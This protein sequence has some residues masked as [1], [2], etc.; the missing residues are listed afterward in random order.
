MANVSC[1]YHPKAEVIDRGELICQDC[2]LVLSNLNLCVK[3]GEPIFSLFDISKYVT[4]IKDVCAN[5]HF[6]KAVVSEA[7]E[8]FN[9]TANHNSLNSVRAMAC[10]YIACKFHK[11]PVVPEDIQTYSGIDMHKLV[12][13][14]EEIEQR[15]G[16]N[17]P[18]FPAESFVAKICYPLNMP[19]KVEK[20]ALVIIRAAKELELLVIRKD[21]HLAVTAIFI[22]SHIM[23]KPVDKRH[24]FS[25]LLISK[26]TFNKIYKTLTNVKT[27][28]LLI[29]A[30]YL[31]LNLPNKV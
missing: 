9:K 7:I 27:I 25:M 19:F 29:P 31:P 12:L 21:E 1:T 2:G 20:L 24:I 18:N 26:R 13:V 4:A 14:S 16:L 17:L 15:F 10:V 3:A 8:V 5:L 28:P 22:A 30:E 11:T 23:D 6:S